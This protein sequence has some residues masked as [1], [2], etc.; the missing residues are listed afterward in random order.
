MVLLAPAIFPPAPVAPSTAVPT[1]LL[2]PTRTKD[3]RRTSAGARLSRAMA[4]MPAAAAAGEA[5]QVTYKALLVGSIERAL[6][7]VHA[8]LGAPA[9]VFQPT[10]LRSRS[11]KQLKGHGQH[12]RASRGAAGQQRAGHHG[13]GVH[14]AA[15]QEVCHGSGAR[16]AS[17]KAALAG[18]AG[19]DAALRRHCHVHGGKERDLGRLR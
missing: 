17:Q 15:R 7:K 1:T 16:A 3:Y 2:N 5:G 9:V 4:G 19:S 18:A 14:G 12:Q 8:P 6:A 11:E 13:T 10:M